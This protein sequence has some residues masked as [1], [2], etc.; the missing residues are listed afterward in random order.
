M[1]NISVLAKIIA[2]KFGYDIEA[3]RAVAEDMVRDDFPKNGITTMGGAVVYLD[4][5]KG[6]VR[7]REA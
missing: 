5:V 1:I 2:F 6:L 4:Y 3:A 7:P